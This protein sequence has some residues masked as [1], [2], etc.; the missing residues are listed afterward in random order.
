MWIFNN[1]FD[2][3]QER[4]LKINFY[5]GD[6]LKDDF[7]KKMKEWGVEKFDIVVGNPPYNQN[8]DLKILKKSYEISDKIVFVHPAT[9][10]LD[11][12][13]KQKRFT[14]IKDLIGN[15]L[16]KSILFNGNFIFGISLFV[17]CSITYINKEYNG[18]ITVIDEVNGNVTIQYDDIYKINKFNRDEYFSIKEKVMKHGDYI[19]NY[20][21]SNFKYWVNLAQIRGHVNEKDSKNPSMVQDDFYTLCPRDLK[22]EEKRNKN[23][24]WSFKTENEAEN[25]LNYI[26]TKFVRFCLSIYKNNS[27]LDRGEIDL[28][29]WL[30]FTQSWDD[31]KLCKYFNIT[32]EEWNYIDNFIPDY[33]NVNKIQ[34]SVGA[35]IAKEHF[36]FDPNKTYK[37]TGKSKKLTSSEVYVIKELKNGYKVKDLSG[38]VTTVAKSTIET[39]N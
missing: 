33:Y 15:Y 20:L 3:M 29:P 27:Q 11:E 37:Y 25:F 12:K 30:D 5:R 4:K 28:I 24:S 31:E 7:D 6:F 21:D 9:W 1:L 35:T 22:V 39:G 19:N 2:R 34:K 13:N 32:E 36:D 18:K 17:P 14:S 10:L 26:K 16:E 8:I 38:N 23:K